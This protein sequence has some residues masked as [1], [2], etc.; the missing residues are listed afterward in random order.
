MK[1]HIC[2]SNTYWLLNCIISLISITICWL[3]PS[4]WSYP[5]WNAVNDKYLTV[6][7]YLCRKLHLPRPET[8]CS[9]KTHLT[10]TSLFLQQT[11]VNF[12][13]PIYTHLISYTRISLT[14]RK[15]VHICLT[16]YYMFLPRNGSSLENQKN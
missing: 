14:T 3:H 11:V 6:T 1:E 4:S 8:I 2:V 13:L 5:I 16:L 12:V 10:P 9:C 7:N 15:F